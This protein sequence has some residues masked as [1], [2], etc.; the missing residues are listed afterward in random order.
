MRKRKRQ[1]CSA[2]ADNL[3]VN[4]LS[5]VEP[6]SFPPVHREIKQSKKLKRRERPYSDIC[7]SVRHLSAR[8]SACGFAYLAGDNAT[9]ARID[10]RIGDEKGILPHRFQIGFTWERPAI[11]IGEDSGHEILSRLLVQYQRPLRVGLPKKGQQKV[12][13]SWLAASRH[14]VE[15]F[16]G[17]FY[18][19]L[20]SM[21]RQPTPKL[22]NSIYRVVIRVSTDQDVGIE[23]KQHDLRGLATQ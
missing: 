11:G 18:D 16:E 20:A 6:Q 3:R 17:H 21:V 15:N 5:D 2:A 14:F 9:L 12:T 8:P 7:T 19:A 1:A 13:V 23:E 22:R 10:Q 4:P